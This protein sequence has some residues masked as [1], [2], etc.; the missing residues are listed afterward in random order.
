[1]KNKKLY[2]LLVLIIFLLCYSAI[3]Y[4]EFGDEQ[5]QPMLN[6]ME[7]PNYL[8]NDWYTNSIAD[9][10]TRA[11]YI[12][13]VSIADNVVG[14]QEITFLLLFMIVYTFI[15]VNIFYLAHLFFNDHKKS[16]FIT[17]LSFIALSFSLDGTDLVRLILTPAMLG[18]LCSITA[19]QAYLRGKNTLAFLVVGV[20]SLFQ[21]VIGTITF[22]LIAGDVVFTK[23][24]NL[25]EKM[26]TF[27]KAW[28]F[29]ILYALAVI[30]LVLV[31]AKTS[32]PDIAEYSS[33]II[34]W[35]AHP[36]HILPSSWGFMTYLVF[37]F[38]LLFSIVAYQRSGCSHKFKTRIRNF[39]FTV[40]LICF[41]GYFFVE[42]IPLSPVVKM[43]LFRVTIILN[44]FGYI[45]IGDYLYNQFLNSKQFLE[46]SFFLLF[47]LAFIAPF[48]VLAGVGVFLGV[49]VLRWQKIDL[50]K[51][52]SG[53]KTLLAILSVSVFAVILVIFNN[54]SEKLV[55]FLPSTSHTTIVYV[56]APILFYFLTVIFLF[57][58]NLRKAVVPLII[59]LLLG[60]FI[61]YP[62]LERDYNY[63]R[64]DQ[65]LFDFFKTKTST[66]SL[67]LWPPYIGVSRLKL[68]RALVVDI[69]HPY[70]DEGMI[71]WYRILQDFSNNRLKEPKESRYYEMKEHYN[72]LETNDF[73]RLQ[74]KYKFDYIIVESGK[75]LSL[76][77]VFS[78]ERYNVYVVGREK[79]LVSL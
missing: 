36:N 67:L 65:E 5:I 52:L 12:K 57:T 32:N 2:Y 45:F 35:F 38:F 7:N 21:V 10:K 6:R 76:P 63:D 11:Y 69:A 53:D 31:N 4:G 47:P 34:G 71:E 19:I 70:T 56:I 61:F 37:S 60:V 66:D 49:E 17:V 22:A 44:I 28:P 23:P 15:F 64:M 46:K 54:F 51:K 27:F 39:F 3:R 59:L 25:K 20:C 9:D 29:F 73:L 13:F 41:M 16:F 79:K 50:F 75:K 55:V 33:Y 24:F 42:I 74:K 48:F 58:N 18:W 30:P 26:F 62:P 68:E 77:L 43:Q 1:M 78:N 72:S 40:L 8:I 14:N